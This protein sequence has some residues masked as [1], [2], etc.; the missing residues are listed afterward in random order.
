MTLIN[1][2][3]IADYSSGR[4]YRLDVNALTDN[5]D[6]IEREIIGET[7][8]MP[9]ATQFSIDC[10][11]LDMETGIGTTSGQGEDPQISL[12]ISRDNGNT[13]GPE[14][15]KSCGKKGDY[16]HRVEWRRLGS[17]R[18]FTPRIKITDPVPTVFV[19]ACVNPEN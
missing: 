10:L 18:F 4:L 9:D 3:I 19:S 1:S 15:W 13:W 16:L 6:P 12:S 11:R 14:L 17:A 8:A 7:I 5:G 2:T